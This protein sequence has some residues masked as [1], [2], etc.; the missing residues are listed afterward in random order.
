M[1]FNMIKPLINH[2]FLTMALS[3]ML[4][5]G[6]RPNQSVYTQWIHT[7][8]AKQRTRLIYEICCFLRFIYALWTSDKC[9]LSEPSVWQSSAEKQRRRKERGL[10]T[11]ERWRRRERGRERWADGLWAT[12]GGFRRDMVRDFQE[13]QIY[14]ASGCSIRLFQ[15]QLPHTVKKISVE[16][17]GSCGFSC[18]RLCYMLK[19]RAYTVCMIVQRGL[20]SSWGPTKLILRRK[21]LL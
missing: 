8:H 19:C 14:P 12:G 6:Q 4:I 13:K 11:K 15:F 7:C 20:E 10:K 1:A 9:L 5:E 17:T 21:N 18:K 2:L 3:L 16:I